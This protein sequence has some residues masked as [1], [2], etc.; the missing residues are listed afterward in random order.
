MHNVL[1]TKQ[2]NVFKMDFQ[3]TF[4]YFLLFTYDRRHSSVSALDMNIL[5]LP[6]NCRPCVER[7]KPV[8][9]NKL[10]TS[11]LLKKGKSILNAEMIEFFASIGIFIQKHLFLQFVFR[12]VLCMCPGMYTYNTINNIFIIL[13]ASEFSIFVKLP[14]LDGFLLRLSDK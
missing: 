14:E 9:Y 7:A 4:I 3:L 5:K 6:M 12:C 11:E 8:K 10:N 2:G 13:I 1:K